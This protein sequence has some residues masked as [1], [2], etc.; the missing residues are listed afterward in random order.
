[1]LFL[2]AIEN[3]DWLAP[4]AYF[5]VFIGFALFLFKAFENW[6]ANKY[7]KPLYRH[8]FISKRLNAS[9]VSVLE[10]EFVFYT[11]L[12]NRNK[13]IFQH[14]VFC[15]IE[16]K[17]FIG[18]ENINL[19]QRKKVLIAATGCMLSFGRK[20]FEYSLI[21]RVLVYPEK[22]YSTVNHAEHIGEFNPKQKTLVLSWRDFEIGYQITDDNRNL[23][24]HEFMHA[25][26]LE[27]IKGR[28]LD[29]VRFSKHFQNI[30]KRLSSQEV[31]DKLDETKYFRAYAFTNQF[32]FMAV[33]VEYFME[34]PEEFKTYFPELYSYTKKLLNFRY[35][36]Y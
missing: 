29:S 26:Q 20:N 21:E 11:L 10:N 25:M 6:F 13:K 34:S 2:Q 1:M 23:G 17:D 12:S 32:E 8:F 22:F 24:I 9:Q 16:N 30:L 19:D 3:I 5:I 15:F 36:G 33:L 14:R 7:D 27:A 31:K 28:D 35:A 18:R 4:Y